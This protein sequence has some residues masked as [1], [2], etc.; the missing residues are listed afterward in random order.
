MTYI[1]SKILGKNELFTL[2]RMVFKQL[3]RNEME[4]KLLYRGS[5]HGFTSNNF[6]SKCDY[7]QNIIV[8]IETTKNMVFG[9]YTSIGFSRD[10][11]HRGYGKDKDVFIYS[12]RSGNNNKYPP[13][14]FPIDKGYINRALCRDLNGLENK[15]FIFGDALPKCGISV[16]EYCNRASYYSFAQGYQFG[17]A[18][19][20][21]L[22]AGRRDISYQVKDI[23]VF[24]L[25]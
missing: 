1:D 23:E 7:K 10:D 19:N 13:K 11:Y 20:G 21:Y 12:I 18:N 24:E 2:D 9:G 17:N 5:E 25:K 15:L 22:L 16:T 6:A 8:I 4:W 3:N 14:I